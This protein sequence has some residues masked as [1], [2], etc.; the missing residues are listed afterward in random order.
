MAIEL[1]RDA[2]GRIIPLDTTMMYR[3]DNSQFHVTDFFY[4]AKPDK[5]FARS[6]SECVDASTLHLPINKEGWEAL[7]DD[8][9]R[10]RDGHI[11]PVFPPCRYFN[12]KC[13]NQKI[14]CD[15]IPDYEK[16][17]GS[18]DGCEYDLFDDIIVRIHMLLGDAE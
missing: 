13:E 1:P 10:A 15:N 11:G 7:L 9:K 4:E 6:G 16:C 3:D 2:N 18:N 12:V 8:L 14:T 17:P 5:W